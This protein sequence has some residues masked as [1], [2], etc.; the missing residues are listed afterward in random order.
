MSRGSSAKTQP[1][2]AH[3]KFIKKAAAFDITPD[4]KLI[5]D[6]NSDDFQIDHARIQRRRP[7]WPV[8]ISWIVFTLAAAFIA[9]RLGNPIIH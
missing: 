6:D 9:Y 1:R 5:L 7:D 8:I 2:G 3:G 4:G